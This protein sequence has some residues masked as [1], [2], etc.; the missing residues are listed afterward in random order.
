MIKITKIIEKCIRNLIRYYFNYEENMKIGKTSVLSEEHQKWI[1][2]K[3]SNF[4]V[5]VNKIRSKDVANPIKTA[6]DMY[7]ES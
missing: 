5:S 4:H 7:F 1:L 3:V 2:T 6:V